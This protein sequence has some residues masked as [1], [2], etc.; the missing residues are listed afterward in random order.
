MQLTT[1]IVALVCLMVTITQEPRLGMITKNYVTLAFI[2]SI[3]NLFAD[4]FPDDIKANAQ[5]INN[6]GIM[7]MGEDQNTF[8]KIKKRLQE[9]YHSEDSTLADFLQE[10]TNILV[11]I[12]YFIV[13]NFEVIFYN[14]FA[15]M[16]CMAIQMLGYY[17]NQRRREDAKHHEHA[18][19]A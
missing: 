12:L 7:K 5:Y 1:P 19:S 10:L 11:N 18:T 6:N 4:S 17:D 15:P 13:V 14:Y 9:H 8:Q 2:L 3:D 16:L